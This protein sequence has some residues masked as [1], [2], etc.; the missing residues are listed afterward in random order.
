[1]SVNEDFTK[2]RITFL[3]KLYEMC[4]NDTRKPVDAFEVGRRLSFDDGKTK[5]IVNYL[6]EKAYVRKSEWIPINTGD[7]L[8]LQNF[9]IIFITS[10]G[11][12]KLENKESRESVSDIH[13]H[14]EDTYQDVEKSNDQIGIQESTQAVNISESKSKELTEILNQLRSKINDLQ[15][16]NSIQYCNDRK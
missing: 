2:D 16:G 4:E 8:P 5:R 3:T 12:D 15:N 11:I 1:V 10:A 13:H 6:L 14:Y 7:A 9:L